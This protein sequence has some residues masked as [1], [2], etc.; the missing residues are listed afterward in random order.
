MEDNDADSAL[1]V[2][3]MFVLLLSACLFTYWCGRSYG[4]RIGYC[5]ALSDIDNKLP[6]KYKLVKQENSETKWIKVEK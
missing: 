2:L 1:S 4:E 6:L 5:Q 3:V